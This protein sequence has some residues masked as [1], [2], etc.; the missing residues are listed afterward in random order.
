M[1][2]QRSGRFASFWKSCSLPG[3]P[4]KFHFLEDGW[5]ASFWKNRNWKKLEGRFGFHF[6]AGVR[7]FHFL[8]AHEDFPGFGS[9]G[10][11]QGVSRIWKGDHGQ[12]DSK[13]GRAPGFRGLLATAPSFVLTIF[14]VCQQAQR[15]TGGWGMK[16]W[17][18]KEPF[19]KGPHYLLESAVER[20]PLPAVICRAMCECLL[21]WLPVPYCGKA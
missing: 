20:F 11:G 6:L 3:D 5:I 18:S 21:S 15:K 1:E 10:H 9:V 14:S 7:I 12:G 8:E 2:A 19:R 13:T 17:D 4:A 16:T